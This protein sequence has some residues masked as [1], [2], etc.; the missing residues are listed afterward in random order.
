[1][2]EGRLLNERYRIKKMV[3]GG[4]MA[5]VYLAHDTILDRDVAIKVLRLE[6]ANDEEFIARFDREAQSATS[7]SHPNIVNIYD[8][9]EEAHILYMVMEYVEGMTL[10]EYIQQHG[11]VDVREAV[12]IMKQLTDAIAHAHENDIVHRDIKPQNILIDTYGNVKVTDFGIAIALSATALTQTNAVLGSV[13]YLSPEQARGGMATKKSDIYALGIVLYE[14]L[15][16]RLPF[17]GETPVAIALKHLQHDTPS[18]RRF[19]QDV[20]QSVENIVLQATAKDPFH[21]YATVRE[22]EA[23]L[24]TALAPDKLNETAYTPPVEAGQET[25]AIPVITDDQFN[26]HV[27]QDTIVHQTNGQTN[28]FSGAGNSDDKPGKKTKKKK[29][30]KKSRWKKWLF[31]FAVFL[32][33]AA[34]AVFIISVFMQPKDVTIPDLTKMEYEEAVNELQ[35]YNLHPDKKL[36]YSEEIEEGHVVKTSPRAGRIVKEDVSVTIYVSDG[37]EKVKFSDYTGRDFSQ[38]KRLLEDKGYEDIIAYEKYSDEPA[39][40]II[41]QIQPPADSEVVPS[42]TR[43]IFEISNGPELISLNNLKGMTEAEAK[44]YLDRKQLVMNVREESSENV[45]EGEVIR[46]EPKADTELKEGASVDV[47]ISL[48]PEEKPP[49]SHDVTFTVPYNPKE[50]DEAQ[51][52]NKDEEKDQ[53]KET[54]NKPEQEADGDEEPEQTVEIYIGDMNHDISEVFKEEK[55]TG[56]KEFTITLTIEA[57]KDAAYKVIRDNEVVIDKTVSYE[58]G[59]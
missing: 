13:H 5:N 56:D 9:G 30:K 3:G 42:E 2:L 41:S 59:E 19:N 4:G 39:G 26:Q 50:E 11:P 58:E 54:E 36:I 35:K 23:V 17:S 44:E 33:L 12:R 37:K 24:D 14:L 48:G 7:L 10:K 31:I 47:Y 34:A 51:D 27:T 49:V 32:I 57:D 46:Q 45:P 21:R 16:G 15:T 55:I 53:D 43:V 22:M 28:E 1:V 40:E 20:P 18:V 8:V 52:Q 6:Y 25:K 38:V 29:T